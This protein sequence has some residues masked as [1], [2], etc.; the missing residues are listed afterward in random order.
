M[1]RHTGNI[2]RVTAGRSESRRR[3]SPRTSGNRRAGNARQRS[4][5]R[6]KFSALV[7]ASRAGRLSERGRAE[8]FEGNDRKLI[9]GSTAYWTRSCADRRG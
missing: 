2:R 7:E 1:T 6:R 3:R 8:Q 9:E 5:C 4:D